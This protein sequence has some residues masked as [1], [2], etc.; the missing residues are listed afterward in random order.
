M[1]KEYNYAFHVPKKDKCLLCT[2]NENNP[3][4]TT[5]EQLQV[6]LLEKE[7]TYKRFHIYQNQIRDST[8]VVSSYDLQKVLA[9][10]YGESMQLY[11]S[12]KYA[13][14]NFTVYESGT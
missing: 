11:Y 1:F 14:F 13:V 8:F 2:K 10:P 12:R 6:H 3:G 4:M 5:N 9:T 7:S